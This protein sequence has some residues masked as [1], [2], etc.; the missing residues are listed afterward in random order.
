MKSVATRRVVLDD[1]QIDLNMLKRPNGRS[2]VNQYNLLVKK[3]WRVLD[4]EH[5]GLGP[6]R[7][8]LG[9]F[10]MLCELATNTDTLGDMFDKLKNT[11]RFF[12]TS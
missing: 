12:A 8:P 9:S 7:K 6:Y 4:D 11:T 1:T 10:R 3:L 2:S 5:I